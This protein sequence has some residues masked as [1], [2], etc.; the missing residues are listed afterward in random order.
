[1]KIHVDVP[2]HYWRSDGL[3]H[4][5]VRLA[6]DAIFAA[7]LDQRH[8]VVL[9]PFT[10]TSGALAALD[11][12]DGL[13]LAYHVTRTGRN[14]VCLKGSALP[15]LWFMDR[16]GYGG[17]CELA[18]SPALQAESEAFDLKRADALIAHYRERFERENF[19]RYPQPDRSPRIVSGD[20]AVFY[21]LQ[22]ND[23]EVLKLADFTQFEVLDAIV[24]WA[25]RTGAKV[26][27]KR[28]PLCRSPM[29]AA[30]L[31]KAAAA[32]G[33]EVLDRSIHDL[34]QA[35]ASVLVANSGV[36]L[37]ALIH[38]RRVFSFAASEYA[39]MTERLTDLADLGSVL[40]SACAR[41]S[42]R[43]RRQLG[44]LLGDYLVDVRDAGRVGDRLR[45]LVAAVDSGG[46]SPRSD[47]EQTRRHALM[48]AM[49]KRTRD[50][51]DHLIAQFPL[52]EGEA[53]D[54]LTELLLGALRLDIR[55]DRILDRLDP[56]ALRRCVMPLVQLGRLD[57]AEKVARMIAG[58]A[59]AGPDDTVALAKVLYRRG[60]DDEAATLLRDVVAKLE[61]P[62][63]ALIFLAR[64]RLGADAAGYDEAGV[65]ADAALAR[66]PENP[67]AL[68]IK[69]RVLFSQQRLG[70]AHDLIV[71]AAALAPDNPTIEAARES[72][73]RAM[74]AETTGESGD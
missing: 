37:E 60:Q 25:T 24:S 43:L 31:D 34:I 53:R 49:D 15:G 33:V 19:S 65:L 66:E 29:I 28:H 18:R 4:A 64:K 7:L 63:D 17:W 70:T 6:Y 16:E 23:D 39:H 50:L 46:A 71:R 12:T 30:A 36:G 13:R 21:A 44:H 22:V 32:P 62:M 3:H 52:T 8:A 59:D 11:H 2:N 56:P 69:A 40:E 72:I 51:V 74:S 57:D 42:G 10:Q 47:H 5:D 9:E 1:M 20:Y 14:V 48:A 35:S 38:G 26:A 68:W 58:G 55:I 27:V 45:R 41:P 73:V 67:L 61:A 54:T